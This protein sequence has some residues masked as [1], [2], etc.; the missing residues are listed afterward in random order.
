MLDLIWGGIVSDF[1]LTYMSLSAALGDLLYMIPEVT[2]VNSTL[3]TASY[4]GSC[5]SAANKAISKYLKAIKA[6]GY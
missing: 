5:E 3:N 1:G 4:I 2:Y 6:N